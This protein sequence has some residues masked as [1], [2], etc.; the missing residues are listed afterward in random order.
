MFDPALWGELVHQT[1]RELNLSRQAVRIKRTQWPREKL[2]KK[3]RRIEGWRGFSDGVRYFSEQAARGPF[4]WPMAAEM[5][6]EQLEERFS[7]IRKLLPGLTDDESEELRHLLD[8]PGT[9]K[10]K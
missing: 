2:A 3:E 7:T 6:P 8:E 10:P 9:P 1:E 5:S 4:V